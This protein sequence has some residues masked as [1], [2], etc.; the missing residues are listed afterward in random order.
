MPNLKN[1]LTQIQFDWLLNIA[2][3]QDYWIDSELRST[4]KYLLQSIGYTQCYDRLQ[5][6]KLLALRRDVIDVSIKH[7]N[8]C[9]LPF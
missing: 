9:D 3:T 4:A 7:D 8:E 6:S 5:Q 1:T 2:T